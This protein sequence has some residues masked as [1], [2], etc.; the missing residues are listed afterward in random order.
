MPGKLAAYHLTGSGTLALRSD[1]H[2]PVQ[3]STYK[4]MTSVFPENRPA[5]ARLLQFSTL[6]QFLEVTP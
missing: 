1:E 4:S 3:Q 6:K 2:I 5:L